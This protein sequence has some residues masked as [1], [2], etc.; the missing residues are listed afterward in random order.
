M[1]KDDLNATYMPKTTTLLADKGMSFENAFVSNPLCCPSRAT[2]MRGQ[3]AHNTEVWFNTNVFDPDP[4]VPDGGWLG[5]KGNGYEDDNVATHLHDAGYTTGLFGKYLND[6]D[7]T[8]VPTPRPHGWDDWFAFKQ[9]KYYNYDV[10]DNGTIKHF[11]TNESDYSTDVLNREVQQFIG[12]SAAPR[13]AFL[14]LRRALCSARPC[15][16]CPSRPAHLRR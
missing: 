11:G 13:Q 8:T 4:N 15:R 16:T 6:Y 14:R 2:I 12:A 1:R 9:T 7:G 10:N 3:Y 5:Y